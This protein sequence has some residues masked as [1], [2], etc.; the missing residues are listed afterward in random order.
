MAS[1]DVHVR[2][3][4]IVAIEQKIEAPSALSVDGKDMIC[5]PGLVDTHWHHWTNILRTFM[6]WDDPKATYFPITAK[7]GVHYTP[8]VS[9]RSARLGLAEALSAGITTTQN[10][11]HNVR[12]PEHADAELRAMHDIGIRGRFAY[13]TAQGQSNEQPMDLKGLAD[14]KEKWT[15]TAGML[16]LAIC[17]RSVDGANAG[18]RGS[19]KA[20]MAK[21]EWTAARELGLPITMHTSGVGGIKVLDETGLLGPDLQLVHPL[22][23]TAEE[24]A[25]LARHNVTYSTSPVG[26]ARRPGE[27]QIAEMVE[28]GVKLSLSVDHVTTFDANLFD[29]MRILATVIQHRYGAKFR[30]TSRQLV[31]MATI[32][33]ARDLGFADAVGSLTPGKRAD[34]ILVRKTDLNMSPIGDPYDALVTLAQPANVDTVIVDGRILRRKNQFTNLDVEKMTKETAESVETLR[35]AAG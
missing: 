24:R 7:Y 21:K 30:L 2:D 28:A 14:T 4:A 17:S 1:G 27:M 12:S 9:Y 15:N 19:I 20:D 25:A 34:I 31:E 5:M 18:T 8:E 13:G 29:S 10:W 11:C 23:T 26:E 16:S 35:K 3:G 33:G 6:R 32:G 22:N